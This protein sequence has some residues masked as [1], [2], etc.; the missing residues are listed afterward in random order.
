MKA[1]HWSAVF[2]FFIVIPF[3][4]EA[5]TAQQTRVTCDNPKSCANLA[6]VKTCIDEWQDGKCLGG[7]CPSGLAPQASTEKRNLEL[8]LY[9]VS[10]SLADA[11]QKLVDEGM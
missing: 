10:P 1:I 8:H 3:R 4:A 9:H 11:I 5:Q 7:Y 2:I 6:C